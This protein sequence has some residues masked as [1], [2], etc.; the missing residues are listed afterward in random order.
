V[1]STVRNYLLCLSNKRSN[2]FSAIKFC[3]VAVIE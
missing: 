3:Y 1:A 2:C